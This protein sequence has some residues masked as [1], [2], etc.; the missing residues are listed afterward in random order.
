MQEPQY[1]SNFN[2]G[3]INTYVNPLLHGYMDAQMQ[4][5]GQLIRCVNMDSYPAGGKIKR[6][7]YTSFLDS[8]GASIKN[9]WSWTKDDGTSTFVYEFSGSVLK[10]YDAGVGTATSWTTCGNGTFTGAHIGNAVL[11]NTMICGDGVGSTRHTT[12]GTSFTN[13]TLAPPGEF[14]EQYLNRIYIGGTS[15]TLFYSSAG[16][17]TNWNTSGTSDSSSLAI[18]DAGR[19]SR[20]MKLNN[21]LLINK[22]SGK[23]FRWDNYTLYDMATN[24]GAIS[25]Y[26]YGAFEGNGF[27]LHNFG[28]FTSQVDMPQL[29]SLPV[30]REIFNENSTGIAG[31][32]FKTAPGIVHR[33]DYF[34]GVGSVQDDLTME[35]LNNGI[36]KYNVQ[37]NEFLNYQFNDNPTAFGTYVDNSGNR[38]MVFG[39][40]TGQVYLY[41]GTA[42]SD[43]NN[44]INAVIDLVFTA[45]TPQFD[46][47]WRWMFA[48]FNPG[49]EAIISVAF[50]D[51]FIRGKK[52]WV[53]IGQASNGIVQFRFPRNLKGISSRSKF[54][55][56][57]IR[58]SSRTARFSFYGLTLSY[59]PVDP[60]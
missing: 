54:L 36:I 11:G 52:N 9:L 51:T 29:I 1:V 4:T 16:D 41:G 6:P 55:W 58:E 21:R 18:P 47:D 48:F 49:C 7:G 44:A 28:I 33:H 34:L 60:G 27:W 14:F 37:K 25:P 12:D 3:G 42:V 31:S 13:T 19:I 30:Q 46:K 38:Q 17:A 2:I 15:S 39:D 57:R 40:A 53:D 35:P 10:Y 45:N 5:D 59:D 26:S 8:Q 56:V 43:N 32:I 50:S 22:N 24:E 20:L 23:I